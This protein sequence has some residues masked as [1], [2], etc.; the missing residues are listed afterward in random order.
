M[1]KKI[2][3]VI[4]SALM[5]LTVTGCSSSGSAGNSALKSDGGVTAFIGNSI[6]EDSLDPVK[7]A[8]SY[9]YPFIN[10]ALIKVKPD[11]GYTGDLAESWEI[12]DD[13]LTYTFKLKEGVKFS[14]SSDFTADDVVFTY[15]EVKSHPAN[16]E[17]I[18]LTRLESV[19]AVDD[20]TVAFHLS[21]RNSAFFDTTARLQIVPSDAYDSESF[22]R[23]PLGTGAWTVLQYDPNQQIILQA[24]E[25]CFDGRPGLDRVSLI[26]MD[27]DSAFA[28]AQ[29]GQIDI[30]MVGAG[31]ANETIPGMSL[32]PF[33]TMD[34][35]SVS[36]PLQKEHSFTNDEGRTVTVGNDVTSD[37]AVRKALAIG[38]DRERIIMNAFNGVGRPAVSFTGNLIWALNDSYDDNRTEEAVSLLESAG[39]TDINS[40]GIREKDGLRC[41][42][43]V[44][45]PGGDNDRYLLAAALSENARELGIEIV[46]KSA[47]WDEIAEL[48][49]S[50]GVVWGWG[51]YSPE[52]IHSLYGSELFTKGLFD[53]VVGFQ[54][55]EID[56]KIEAA[57][58]A[59]TQDEATENWKAAQQLAN[60]EYSYLF[61]V[62]I[63]HCYFVN[64]SLDLSADTQ[65]PH[66]H[67]HGIPVI[68][69]MKDWKWK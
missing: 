28:A 68:C 23:Y 6:F 34:V 51:Q 42:F 65:I 15:N 31:F 4:A 9:G 33:E 14:D 59:N 12:S 24:N 48:E 56:E 10:N 18:D 46:V 67:G 45:A 43:D 19:E 63:E 3:A 44:Y 53:N 58:T 66:P 37:I 52:L 64:D 7:G 21:E 29:S 26:Y 62:N 17:N 61:L 50:S 32:I 57:V 40:D 54:S 49:F 30:V 39:W 5:L 35:R 36:L 8:M 60:A 41:S 69:N 22:D 11:S 27:P 38:I 1:F 16:N 20:Y 55:E 13:A 47:S 2:T 25:N